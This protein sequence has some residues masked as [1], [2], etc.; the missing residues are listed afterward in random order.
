MNTNLASSLELLA[1]SNQGNPMGTVIMMVLMFVM[2]YFILI[3]PQRKRQKELEAKVK[4]LK[5]GM[6]VVTIGGING[7][8]ANVKERTLVLKVADNVKIEFEKSAVATV[9]TKDDEKAGSAPAKE[10]KK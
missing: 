7:I 8:V 10:E 1:Q 6:K 4:S 9:V 5:T 3:R 2:F